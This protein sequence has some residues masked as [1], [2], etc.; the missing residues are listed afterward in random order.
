[1]K[2]LILLLLFCL[3]LEQN[4]LS[5][6]GSI[7]ISQSSTFKFY[8]NLNGF[9][10]GD[11]VYIEITY[12]DY[13][14]YV[15]T[16]TLKYRQSNSYSSSEFS[17]Y[18]T[19][20]SWSS[21]SSSNYKRTKYYTIKLNGNY[22]Y[23]LFYFTGDYHTYYTIK[24]SS[25]SPTWII[26]VCVSAL[27]AIV[28]TAVIFYWYK[29]YRSTPDYASRV[30]DPLTYP[31]VQPQPQTPVYTQPTYPTYQPYVVQPGYH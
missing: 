17:S 23:L 22:N 19:P 6:Y 13:S 28:A 4:Q 10:S 7:S 3:T 18:F 5:Q 8:L 31:V 9:K 25:S 30:D 20:I 27:V 21:S 24:H 15:A 14:I 26:I 16:P 12:Y 1:M 2:V 29:R 11:K